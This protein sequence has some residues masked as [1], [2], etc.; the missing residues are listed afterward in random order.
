MYVIYMKVEKIII[1]NYDIFY[2]IRKHDTHFFS[3]VFK[4][5]ILRYKCSFFCDTRI[6]CDPTYKL[7]IYDN[8]F[9]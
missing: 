3:N 1:I 7:N 5:H 9:H 6:I 4:V 2:N 8:T